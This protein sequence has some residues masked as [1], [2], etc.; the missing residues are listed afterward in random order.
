M[1]Y[2]S[3]TALAALLLA[4]SS[5]SVFARPAITADNANLRSGPGVEDSVV[6]VIPDDSSIDVGHCAGSWCRVSWNG[7]DGYLSRSLIASGSERG[8]RAPE[9]GP[10]GGPDNGPDGGAYNAGYAY[11]GPYD[12]NYGNY[13]YADDSYP[14][15]FFGGDVGGYGNRRYGGDRHSG[16]GHGVVN[17]QGNG[18]DPS[19]V[20]AEGSGRGPNAAPLVSRASTQGPQTGSQHTVGGGHS[21]GGH[22]GGGHAG[23]R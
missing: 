15:Y 10:Q 18:H 11:N 4:A 17:Y 13:G 23:I 22:F 16:G 19:A 8:T 2:K 3:A 9:G 12:D 6:A 21:S 5:A 1:Y 14:G 7:V 20:N